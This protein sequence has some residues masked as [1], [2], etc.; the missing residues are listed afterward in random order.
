MGE[1]FEEAGVVGGVADGDAEV[2][3]EGV[4]ADGADDDAAG[5]EVGEDTA[6]V[7][8]AE[9]DEVARTGDV[10]NAEVVEAGGKL[11]QAGG[12]HGGGADEVR[13]VIERG[14]GGGLGDRGDVKR[15]A[16][17]VEET[18]EFGRAVAVALSL[19]HI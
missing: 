9:E 4:D 15:R 13:V 8:D 3:G 10:F 6:G 18:D 17:A 12:V 1:G 5:L 11:A 19:I 14:E 16:S 2:F 7:A